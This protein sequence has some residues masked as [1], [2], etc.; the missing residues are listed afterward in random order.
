MDLRGCDAIETEEESLSLSAPNR[1]L[2]EEADVREQLA[3]KPKMAVS[4]RARFAWRARFARRTI[5]A[6]QA[7]LVWRKR[8]L[9]AGLLHGL[10]QPAA[11]ARYCCRRL[12]IHPRLMQR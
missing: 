7:P 8:D 6:A 10:S 12:E 1:S 5:Q 2:Q 11:V 4:Q 3:W 9:V